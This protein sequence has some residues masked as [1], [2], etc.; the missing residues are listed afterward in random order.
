MS[1]IKIRYCAMQDIS[2]MLPLM[3]QLGY[4]V[5]EDELKARFQR[6]TKNDGYGVA[7]ACL[8]SQIV[9]WV[10]W[11]KSQ[12]FISDKTR[13][14]IEGVVVDERYR[15]Q[16]I[17]KRLMDFV[18]NVAQQSS[19]SIVDLTSGLRRAKDGSH[20]FYKSLGYQNDGLMAKLYLR[21]E[22]E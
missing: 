21:K 16:A 22:I 19:P 5:S 9:G 12:L 15:G 18:E 6:F 17:G 8:E 14:H 11:S 20:E 1:N 3:E 4:K 13:F 2:C 10:A 7:V